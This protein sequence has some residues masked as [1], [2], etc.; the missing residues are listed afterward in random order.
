[1][2]PI[3]RRQLAGFVLEHNEWLT[4]AKLMAL[5]GLEIGHPKKQSLAGLAAG[6][7]AC[8]KQVFPCALEIAT[9]GCGK[10]ERHFRTI[11]VEQHEGASERVGVLFN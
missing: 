11:S 10:R 6:H 9:Q 1:M 8:C 2:L 7:L 5:A 4:C 3:V